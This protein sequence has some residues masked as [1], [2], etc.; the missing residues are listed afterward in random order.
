MYSEGDNDYY[1]HRDPNGDSLFAGSIFMDGSNNCFFQDDNTI[2]YGHNMKNGSMFGKLKQYLD[3]PS[4][5]LEYPLFYIYTPHWVGEYRIIGMYKAMYDEGEYQTN[6]RTLE[7]YQAFLEMTKARS[8]YDT[9]IE[10]DLFGPV[11]TLSSCYSSGT[12]GVKTIVVIQRQ[13]AS[14]TAGGQSG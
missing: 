13:R 4:Y 1:L 3:D 6:F 9:G 5:H 10:P 7:G 14:R 12:E 11:I 2:I 8:L